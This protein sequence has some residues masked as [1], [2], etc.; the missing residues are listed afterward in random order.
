MK[1]T[2]AT[3]SVDLFQIKRREYSHR[4]FH[5]AQRLYPWRSSESI[6]SILIYP[7]VQ[8]PSTLG[9]LCNRMGWY[10]PEHGITDC[11]VHL[12]LLSDLEIDDREPPETAAEFSTNHIQI[13]IHESSET[14]QLA[15]QVDQILVWDSTRR[16]D[17]TTVKNLEKVDIID[18]AYYSTVECTTW[19]RVSNQALSPIESNHSTRNFNEL[20]MKA[21]DADAA[22]V[23]ATGPSLDEALDFDFPENSIKIVCNS[24][25][26]NEELLEQ[27]DPDIIVFADP[28]HFGPS[29]Y[30]EEFRKDLSTT[31]HNYDCMAAFP[32]QYYKLLSH[33]YP[34]LCNQFIQLE[35]K[36]SD[37]PIFP[38]AEKLQVMGTSNIMTLFMLPIA[39][40]LSDELYIIGA[41]G[42]EDNESYFWKH[43]DTAQYNDELMR[44][45]AE[46][47]PS[48]FRDRVY[49]DYYDQ[50][51]QTLT[52]MIEYGEANGIESYNLTH[53]YI[54]CL[55]E[56]SITPE[57]AEV[58]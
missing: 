17:L 4:A 56:R 53:S 25:V 1:N 33:H 20:K 22:Y 7:S 48:F 35:S 34:E 2:I 45:V 47:H 9:D 46:T 40:S 57:E 24:I 15:G 50:H 19:P 12:P 32:N 27:I 14:F 6:E 51:V 52:E 26:K 37:E 41:D 23:F 18:P 44:S 16:I 39:M 54:P 8:S 36:S 49:E 29:R 3:A 58:I 13:S 55:R 31:L 28:V 5:I 43:S 21:K 42:R 30:A 38:T 11:T 10:L